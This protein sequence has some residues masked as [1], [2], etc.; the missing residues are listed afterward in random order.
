MEEN[1]KKLCFRCIP[2]MPAPRRHMYSHRHT[3]CGCT[4]YTH[5]MG[6]SAP[7]C[8]LCWICTCNPAMGDGK[9]MDHTK[10]QLPIPHFK[11]SVHRSVHKT[12]VTYSIIY[13]SM[14]HIFQTL[15]L[16]HI[17]KSHL[18]HA[19]VMSR[20]RIVFMN[21]FDTKIVVWRYFLH[22]KCIY[23]RCWLAGTNIWL[24]I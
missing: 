7:C 17:R 18:V 1:A 2:F 20:K 22:S 11:V 13:K 23:L 10:I 24:K 15:M 12:G 9:V 16:L 3:V 4:H 8:L 14:G 5:K 6:K 21:V 19:I